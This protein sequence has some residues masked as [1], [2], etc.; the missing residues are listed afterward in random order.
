MADEPQYTEFEKGER[1]A[2]LQV[3]SF[4]AHHGKAEVAD[5]CAQR[6]HDIMMD[7]RHRQQQPRRPSSTV[8][9]FDGE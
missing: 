1:Q 4:I 8:A 9:V 5:Y 3:R 6:L 2:L 7:A